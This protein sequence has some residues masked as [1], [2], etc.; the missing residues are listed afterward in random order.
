MNSLRTVLVTTM[1]ILTLAVSLS[2]GQTVSL[3]K[4]G[5]GSWFIQGFNGWFTNVNGTLFFDA[6][7]FDSTDK[8]QSIVERLKAMPTG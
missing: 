4:D 8:L 2:F 3:V 5:G 7:V 6:T 1:F